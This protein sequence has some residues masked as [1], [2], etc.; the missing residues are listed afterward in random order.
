MFLLLSPWLSGAALDTQHCTA[1]CSPSTY[2]C[3][4]RLQ[5]SVCLWFRW[6]SP[7]LEHW[8]FFIL[9]KKAA[10]VFVTVRKNQLLSPLLL[11]RLYS[12]PL[13]T[14]THNMEIRATTSQ[15][16]KQR[17]Y[18]TCQ[19]PNDLIVYCG[20]AAG[21][22]AS[23]SCLTAPLCKLIIMSFCYT[24]AQESIASVAF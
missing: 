9:F 12:P 20:T 6:C 15:T 11:V 18:M 21:T 22:H 3:A 24:T 7:V 13:T 2:R 16:C 5:P 8:G 10:E 4:Q 23:S 1:Q 19:T 14:P 17:N